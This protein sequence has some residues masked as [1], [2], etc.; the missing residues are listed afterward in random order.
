MD[1]VSRTNPVLVNFMYK[2]IFGNSSISNKSSEWVELM[3]KENQK[4]FE[5]GLKI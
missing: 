3:A 1:K 5:Y 4:K 2:L